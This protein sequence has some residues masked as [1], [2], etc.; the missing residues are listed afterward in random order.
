MTAQ[1]A[2]KQT[3]DTAVPRAE[4]S[5]SRTTLPRIQL[6]QFSGKFE[7][8]PTFRDLF[9]FIIGNDSSLS[10]VEKLHYLKVNL[11]SDADALIK[12]LP[13][14]AE[15]NQRAWKMLTE[16][17]ENK[18]LLVRSCL[19]KFCALSKMKSESASELRKVL[20]GALSTANTLESIGHPINEDL[21]AFFVVELLDVRTRREWKNSIND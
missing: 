14:T 19:S 20:H 16:Q 10:A 21:F 11:K 2:P 9:Q 5:A 18:R 15:N 7:D 8:W 12:N 13:T 6:P 4:P 3:A 17:F 1:L